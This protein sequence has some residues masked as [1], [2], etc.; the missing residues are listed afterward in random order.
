LFITMNYIL[1]ASSSNYGAVALQLHPT[2]PR[3]VHHGQLPPPLSRRAILG[4][5]ATL[6]LSA[7]C[8]DIHVDSSGRPR[9]SAGAVRVIN[10]SPENERD[11]FAAARKFDHIRGLSCDLQG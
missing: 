6:I 2:I 3:R 5:G 8:N 7:Y 10:Q 11:M 1:M 9:A 4:G